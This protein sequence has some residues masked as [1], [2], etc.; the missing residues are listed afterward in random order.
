MLIV[1]APAFLWHIGLCYWNHGKN[2][3]NKNLLP[4]QYIMNYNTTAELISVQIKLVT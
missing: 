3:E 2:Y 1:V 4:L